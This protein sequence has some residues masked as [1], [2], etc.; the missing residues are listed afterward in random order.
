MSKDSSLADRDTF[1]R[2]AN[3]TVLAARSDCSSSARV[4]IAR[5]MAAPDLATSIVVEINGKNKTLNFHSHSDPVYLGTAT[6]HD[7]GIAALNVVLPERLP[8]GAPHSGVTG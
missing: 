6:T 1:A 3:S 7:D 8:A 4:C 5:C 2:W